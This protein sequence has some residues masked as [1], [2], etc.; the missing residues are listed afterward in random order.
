MSLGLPARRALVVGGAMTGAAVVAAL[1]EEGIAVKV[2]DKAKDA[3]LKKRM[4]ELAAI[5]A[6]TEL[7]VD[8]T[9]L[10]GI[11][12]V[13]PSPGVPPNAPVLSEA[14]L[15]EVPILSEPELAYRLTDLDIVGITG[16]NG[17]TTT[18]S[19]VGHILATARRA[20]EVCGNIGEKTLVQAARTAAEG[21]VLIAELS[22]FQ[23]E[24]T[25]LFR[26][27]VGVLLNLTQDHT[28]W[29]GTFDAY[30]EAK[31]KLFRNQTPGDY[32]VMNWDDPI[33][34][35]WIPSLAARVVPISHHVQL[36]GGVYVDRGSLRTD[37]MGPEEEICPIEDLLIRGHHN[38]DNA[39]A[40]CAVALCLGVQT[41][42]IGRALASFKA[43][44]HRLEE[45]ETADGRLW[46]NDSK[47]TNPDATVV[48]LAAYDDPIVLLG[49]RNKGSEFASLVEVVA[50]RAKGA[51]LFGEAG[52]ELEEAF[53]RGG[54]TAP[55][56]DGLKEAVEL[57]RR[58]SSP[59]DVILL[60]PAC[61]SFDEFKD[62]KER[63]R[64]FKAWATG[65]AQH[66]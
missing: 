5:G 39:M 66:A 29:H 25:S 57:A 11:D 64:A 9:T 2:I 18:T 8:T 58:M 60:S 15:K 17:K 49:G 28:D 55:R 33:V 62:Y 16:T 6:Q 22:S 23:L 20:H 56:V 41:H 45:F 35:R 46:V 36:E 27:K 50:T 26:P 10:D 61:A 38:I 21:S 51:I 40:A 59:G 43:P 12:F 52:V 32:A 7:G 24:Y 48:A 47:A 30:V 14:Q 44:E 53:A 3:K 31:L 4:R 13:V 19:L 34:R 54:H 37:F 42:I 63:G 65:R 1:I